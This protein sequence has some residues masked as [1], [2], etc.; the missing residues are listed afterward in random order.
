MASQKR[1]LRGDARSHRHSLDEEVARERDVR[2]S[3]LM[4]PMVPHDAVIATYLSRH[5]EPST[6]ELAAVLWRRGHRILAPALRGREPRW[7]AYR[8]PSRLREG[9]HGVPEP[10]GEVL[11]AATLSE[12]DIIIV[13]GLAAG[14]DG[15][16]LGAGAGWYDRALTH[17]RPD[18]Q[19][20]LPL[21]ESELFDSVPTEPH[22]IRV[23]CIVTESGVYEVC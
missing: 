5:G 8:G 21:N 6:R 18:A 12:A 17:A 3:R 9:E 15:T 14:R 16:R 4:L 1:Q 13:A 23:S 2:R 7:A 20:W 22:D 11:P 19:V 10:V